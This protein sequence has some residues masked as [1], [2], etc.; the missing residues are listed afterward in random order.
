MDYE[1]YFTTEKKESNSKIFSTALLDFHFAPFPHLLFN[2][3]V[4]V[5]GVS[6]LI[7]LCI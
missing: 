4:Q 2:H 7:C 5:C 6:A 3:S 1:D